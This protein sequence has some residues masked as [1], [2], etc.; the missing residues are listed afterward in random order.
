MCLGVLAL[1]MQSTFHAGEPWPTQRAPSAPFVGPTD[2]IGVTI[3][4][5]YVTCVPGP[6]SSGGAPNAAAAAAEQFAIMDLGFGLWRDSIRQTD[7]VWRKTNGFGPI[8]VGTLTRLPVSG[9]GSG[10]V[11]PFTCKI[12]MAC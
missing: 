3:N 5:R 1:D 7:K 9:K 6:T 10:F 8:N 2:S 4:L 11:I 12:S